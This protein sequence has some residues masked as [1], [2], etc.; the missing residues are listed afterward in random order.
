MSG[1][2]VQSPE[3]GHGIPNEASGLPTP[4]LAL[5]LS[6]ELSS[7]SRPSPKAIYSSSSGS[8]ADLSFAEPQRSLPPSVSSSSLSNSRSPSNLRSQSHGRSS[9]SASDTLP[10]YNSNDLNLDFRNTIIRSFAPRVAVYASKDTED[11]MTGKGFKGGL[12]SLLRPYGERLQGKVIIRDS[13]GS[14]KICDDFGIRFVDSQG[15]R[16]TD[17]HHT[18]CTT[19]G[20]DY[21]SH[22]NDSQDNLS[23][24]SLSH[25][26][27]S[28][29][30]IDQVL[31][32]C[33]QNQDEKM[34]GDEGNNLVYG[35][36]AHESQPKS[37]QIYPI[38]LRKLLSSTSPV[39]FETFTHPVA[40]MIA[41]SSHHQAPI[42]ALRQ[43]YT[44]T[45]HGGNQTP[46]WV[47]TDYLRYYVLIHD[48][49]KD[50]ITK[51]TALFDLMKRHFGLH[52]H[53]LRLRGTECVQTD[54]DSVQVPPCEWLSA[55]E[56]MDSISAKGRDVS[57][58]IKVRSRG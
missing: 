3:Y 11:F 9:V 34:N 24:S 41:V 49:E 6:R 46:A 13:I 47:G 1:F 25:D 36:L 45:S 19:F 22:L 30:V 27:Y 55:E 50:D 42:E 40:C 31:Q 53:L 23:R 16:R 44:D 37:S 32:R 56:E 4:E 28:G 5:R 17:V 48:E 29:A 35:S 57:I 52:C 2:N 54:D 10:L 38:Y 58:S 14:S 33:L 20:F 43:L 39:P 7:S 21:G 15:R 51:S 18:T 8:K 26:R 12:C